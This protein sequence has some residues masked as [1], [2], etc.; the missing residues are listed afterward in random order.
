[1]PVPVVMDVDTGIDDAVAL[2]LAVRSPELDLVGVGSVAGNVAADVAARN[3][4]RV[5]EAADAIHVPVA[6][7]ASQPLLEP[8]HEA[9]NVHGADGLGETDQPPPAGA[10]SREHAVDQLLRLSHQHTG[11]LVVVAVGP[12]TNLA[13]ALTRDPGLAQRLGRIV[14]MGGSARAGG[15]RRPWAEA[16]IAS[17]P[18]AAEVVFRC[19]TPRTMVG[20]DV[21]LQVTVDE[22]DVAALD[23]SGDP[24]GAFAAQILPFYLD[25]YAAWM[26]GRRAALHD[27]LAVAAVVDP[28]V[29]VTRELPVAVETSG[30]LTRGMT[31]VDLR[32]LRPGVRVADGPRTEVALEVDADRVRDLVLA[33]L[34][35]RSSGVAGAAGAAGT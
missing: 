33:R 1:M 29:V 17:D 5:L 34:S 10:P 12:L 18:E 4:L 11:E 16:N 32:G 27:P 14:L 35:G 13:L 2:L 24:A 15:N 3:S 22:A 19:P 6:V 28:E 26:G 7:G 30:H 20:L 21:T 31:V 8:V 25:A 9:T 23:R